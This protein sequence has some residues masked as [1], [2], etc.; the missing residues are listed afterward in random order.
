MA[1]S[2]MNATRKYKP[3]EEA[4]NYVREYF[5]AQGVDLIPAEPGSG[6]DFRDP[7]GALFVEV[8]GTKHTSIT[9]VSP[10][11]TSSQYRKAMECLEAGKRFELHVILGIGADSKAHYI[12]PAEYIRKNAVEDPWWKLPLR[13]SADA[14]LVS[15]EREMRTRHGTA[16]RTTGSRTSS[17]R[18]NGVGTGSTPRRVANSPS[19]SHI[20][21]EEHEHRG[22]STRRVIFR[23]LRRAVREAFPDAVENPLKGYIGYG[24]DRTETGRLSKTFLQVEVHEQDILIYLRPANYPDPREMVTTAEEKTGWTCNKLVRLHDEK[25]VDYAL[26]LIRQSFEDVTR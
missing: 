22:D 26:A 6:P 25:D 23:R 10:Y 21:V 17:E 5:K 19:Q 9:S 4:E 8:K 7:E 15:G 11:L 1:D 18:R 16:N 2:K 20:T 12:F 24:L 3:G 14:Y 13:R